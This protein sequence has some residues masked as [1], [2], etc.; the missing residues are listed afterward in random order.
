MIDKLFLKN[1]PNPKSNILHSSKDYNLTDLFYNTNT[2]SEVN[3]LILN[4]NLENS[5]IIK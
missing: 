4:S 1:M 5:N 3:N 2:L